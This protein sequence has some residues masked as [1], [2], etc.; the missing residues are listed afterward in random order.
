MATDLS[1][2]HT[3]NRNAIDELIRRYSEASNNHSIADVVL[4]NAEF[5]GRLPEGQRGRR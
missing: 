3:I 5:T 1:H 4:A 2:L